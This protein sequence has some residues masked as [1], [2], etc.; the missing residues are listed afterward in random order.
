M[1][2]W[3]YFKPFEYEIIGNK[4]KYINAIFTFDIETSSIIILN[5]KVYPAIIYKDLS[6][7]D[8]EKAKP[9]GF[10]YIWQLGIN[11]TV[12][13]GRTW[14]ELKNFLEIIEKYTGGY[15]K[16]FFIHNASFEFQFLKGVF[17]FEKVMARNV[18]H[19]MSACFSAYNIEIHCTYY[20]SNVSL[21]KLAEVYHLPVQKKSGDLDYS[22]IRTFSTPLTEK[23][24][25]YCE[26]DCL[27]IYH[28]IL[29]ELEKYEKLSKIP[30]TYTGHVRKE[31]R[32]LISND[33]KYKSLVRKA[34]NTDPHIYNLLVQA[35][36]RWLYSL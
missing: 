19:V 17:G 14:D 28:Y 16:Y 1:K 34:I 11:E 7:K 27:V 35:F 12:Y 25:S 3:V 15:K 21:K 10:M 2:N 22:K 26:Y 5:D 31:F 23:E 18:R 8:K 13:Y 6:E 24:L 33:F 30:A 4:N 20:M 29:F 36:M 9:Y 32:N